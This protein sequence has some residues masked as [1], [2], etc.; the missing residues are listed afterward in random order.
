MGA[1]RGARRPPSRGAAAGGWPAPAGRCRRRRRQGQRVLWR[2]A[3]A[4]SV[5]RPGARLRVACEKASKAPAGLGLVPAPVPALRTCR[6]TLRGA[7]FLGAPARG[8]LALLPPEWPRSA[9]PSRPSSCLPSN[10]RPLAAR[11][12]RGSRDGECGLAWLLRRCDWAP[13]PTRAGGWRSTRISGSRQYRS[14]ADFIS[15]RKP[16]STR[17]L[18]RFSESAG[19]GPPVGRAWG[20][21]AVQGRCLA[22]L[23]HESLLQ[24]SS[25]RSDWGVVSTHPSSCLE[26]LLPPFQRVPRAGQ[27]L[28]SR[29]VRRGVLWPRPSRIWS[30]PSPA[31]PLVL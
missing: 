3:V 4:T 25:S 1:R 29:S 17:K 13:G 8:P 28:A 10:G 21:K 16:V 11:I 14:S 18:S 27:P 23:A 5:E 20:G 9:L 12:P 31:P 19:E 2:R 22:A 26:K 15:T 7:G 24:A 6:G 30:T